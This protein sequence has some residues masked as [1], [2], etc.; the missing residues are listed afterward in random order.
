MLCGV[1]SW[2]ILGSPATAHADDAEDASARLV[3]ALGGK[4]IRDETLPNKPVIEVNL[5]EKDVLD[6]HLKGLADLKNLTALHLSGSRVTNAG[7]K[8]LAPLTNLRKFSIGSTQVSDEGLKELASLTKLSTLY[9]W[10]TNVKGPGLR[11]LA[12]LKHLETLLLHGKGVTDDTLIHVGALTSLTKLDLSNHGTSFGSG[13]EIT[14]AG[15]AGLAPL[16]NLTELNLWGNCRLGDRAC[17]EL[18]PLQKLTTLDLNSAHVTDVGLKELAKL[19]NLTTLKLHAAVPE[20]GFPRTSVTSAGLKE[21]AA[22][23]HLTHLDLSYTHVDDAGMRTLSQMNLSHLHLN[24]TRVTDAGLKDLVTEPRSGLLGIIAAIVAVA[25]AGIVVSLRC[26]RG[27]RTGV[28]AFSL[29]GLAGALLVWFGFDKV[30]DPRPTPLASSLT[31]L[32]IQGTK[33]TNAGVEQLR[34]ALPKCII[35]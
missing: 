22:L 25:F 19:K 18:V 32:S 16:E 15:L 3:V 34:T 27:R 17:K 13:N 6:A 20:G 28:L 2:L 21:L 24:S 1:I 8:E 12:S 31:E 10:R 35:K 4:V 14:D 29:A 33:I 30:F 5:A 23:K 7:L 9:L 11:D 26:A